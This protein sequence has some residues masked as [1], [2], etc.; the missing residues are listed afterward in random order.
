M[1]P[2]FLEKLDQARELA[3]IPFHVNSGWRCPAH[4]LEIDGSPTSSHLKGWAAD[5]KAVTGHDKYR[6]VM[7]ARDSGITRIGVYRKKFIH[8]DS[9]PDKPQENLFPG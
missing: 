6:I 8:L 5:I 1:K 3:G 7:A 4:N 9:D 2:E